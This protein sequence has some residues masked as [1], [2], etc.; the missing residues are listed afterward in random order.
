MLWKML[1]TKAIITNRTKVFVIITKVRFACITTIMIP[2]Y[3][4]IG[5][6]QE[7]WNMSQRAGDAVDED[8]LAL[9]KRMDTLQDRA[10]YIQSRVSELYFGKLAFSSQQGQ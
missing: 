10:L 5:A 2:T 1:L 4:I 8:S 9:G 3:I 7:N 6:A